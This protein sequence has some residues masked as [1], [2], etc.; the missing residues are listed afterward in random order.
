MMD[1]FKKSRHVSQGTY[2]GMSRQLAPQQQ[3]Q[4]RGG[5]K[6]AIGGGRVLGASKR[7]AKLVRGRGGG[8]MAMAQV[9]ES[10]DFMDS[11]QFSSM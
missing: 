10:R 8:S 3:P 9:R 4:P 6:G 11:I 2:T 7:G 5:A 1:G